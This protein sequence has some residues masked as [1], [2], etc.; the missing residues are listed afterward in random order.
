MLAESAVPPTVAMTQL[1]PTC[2]QLRMVRVETIAVAAADPCTDQFPQVTSVGPLGAAA[3][4]VAA[5]A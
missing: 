3:A 2:M 4:F 5:A 1:S